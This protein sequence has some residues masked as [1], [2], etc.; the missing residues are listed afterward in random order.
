M[1]L[2]PM[3]PGSDTY[4]PS[5]GLWG[6]MPLE[7]IF[8]YTDRNY[9][10]GL[11]DDLVGFGPTVAVATNVG[12]YTSNGVA[13]KS[14]EQ[15]STSIAGGAVA[16]GAV[17]LT[18]TATDNDDVNLQAGGGA[19]CPFGVVPGTHNTLLFE[20]RFKISSVTASIANFFVG[21]AG[22]GACVTD[23]IISDSNA[24]VTDKSFLG[25]GR[26]D[27]STTALGLFYERNAGTVGTVAAVGT[28]VADTYIK[29]GFCWSGRSPCILVPYI[30]GV[31]MDGVVGTNKLVSAASTA[32]TP[33]PDALMTLFAGIKQIDGSV[34]G[35]LTL[36]WWAV[37]QMA[38]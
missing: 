26:L 36:D 25:F 2:R 8:G 33:W 31:A 14:F 12:H 13:Y 37:G 28:L 22:A 17:A 16:G 1:S 19:T 11:I 3:L 38:A 5:I 20:A 32:A 27:A 7:Y 10:T 24:F 34:A 21:L 18:A 4:G 6:K 29:A 30:D 9:G 35:V 15:N 23:G